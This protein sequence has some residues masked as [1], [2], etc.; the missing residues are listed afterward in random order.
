M[1]VNDL[2]NREERPPYVRFERRP[3]ED[4]AASLD[5]G[6]YVARDVDFALSTPAYSK[7]C[8]EQKVSQWL[9]NTEKNV[10]EGR[11]PSSWLETWKKAL[12]SWR[13]G[14][15]VPLNGTAIRG[16]GLISPA[17][18][19]M[20][21]HMNC[22]T[23]EDLAAANDEGLRCIGMGAIELR[24]KAKHWLQTMTDNGPL[25]SRLTAAEMENAALKEQIAT[26]SRQVKILMEPTDEERGAV[27]PPGYERLSIQP[28]ISASDLLDEPAPP[29]VRTLRPRVPAK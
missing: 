14:Q 22:L 23:V 21:I 29:P 24:A 20:L 26:L 6:R 13:N 19:E 28:A 27:P 4:K 11:I 2:V 15:E 12:E 3:V 25:A 9:E 5:S 17:Q 7:D 18:Q 10:R 16:W 8:V 1:A